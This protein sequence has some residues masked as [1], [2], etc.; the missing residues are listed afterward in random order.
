VVQQALQSGTSSG[1]LSSHLAALSTA[2]TQLVMDH[3]SQALFNSDRLAFGM[4]LAYNLVPHLFQ[5]VEWDL[6]L[7]NAVGMML[8]SCGVWL[9]ACLHCVCMFVCGMTHTCE[10]MSRH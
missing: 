7:S 6:F 4:H 1:N 3:V 8:S 9:A 5:A 2:L 10:G